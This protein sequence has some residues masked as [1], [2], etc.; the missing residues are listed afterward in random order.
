[1]DDTGG[2][3]GFVAGLDGPGAAF[4][5]TGGEE[6]A[7]AQQAVG[8][9]DEAHHAGLGQAHLFQE[10]LP[11]VIFLDLGNLGLGLGGNHQDLGILAGHGGAHGLDIGIP[12]G[13]RSFIYVA[14][15]Q[16]RLV[17]EQVKVFGHLLLFRI[18]GLHLAA[19]AALQQHLAVALQQRKKLLGLFV[20]AG[21]GHLLHL[22]DAVLHR[23]QI[24]D[25]QFGIHHFLVAN[26][27][28]RA[29][30]VHNVAVVEAAQHVQNGVGLADVGQ[31]LVAQAL[32]L[33]SALYQA[34]D[35]HDFHRGGNGAL[36]LADV[37]EHLEAFVGHIGGAHVGVD[38]AEREVGAL[39]L[40]AADAIKQ[41]RLAYIGQAYYSTF[42]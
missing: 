42:Q 27:I 4:V 17:G 18:L 13:G 33:G 19:V 15:I 31:E 8:A 6:G 3:G 40:P 5:G 25:L 30:Y 28:H 32:A 35:V 11:I 22:L 26:G 34:G 29:V 14:H 24:L 10:H 21:G 9:L 1:M 23:L 39:G 2:A 41:S 37:G 7:K 38:G 12:A 16:H 20:A 36:G